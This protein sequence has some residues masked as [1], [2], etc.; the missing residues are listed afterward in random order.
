MS[1]AVKKNR[2]LSLDVVRGMTIA[3][4]ILVNNPGTWEAIHSPLKHAE[5]HG[6][7]PTDFIFPFFL[8][9]VGTAIPL[10]HSRRV[11]VRSTID[12]YWKIARRSAIIFLLALFIAAFPVFDF[13]TL[14]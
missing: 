10:A 14:R 2:L 4:M 3:G 11:E 5:W 9:I 7:T 12:I 13:S 1:E 8:F 6:I